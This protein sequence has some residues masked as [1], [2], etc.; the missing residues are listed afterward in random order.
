MKGAMAPPMEEPLSNKAVANPRSCFGNHSETALVAAGQFPDSAAPRKKRKPRKEQNPRAKGVKRETREYQ[1]TV[2]VK[3]RLVPTRSIRRPQNVWQRK[4]NQ[5][6][7]IT[8]AE[9][10]Q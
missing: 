8:M 7:A 6:K 3:P 1:A 2:M 4:K 10:P 5:R 9:S